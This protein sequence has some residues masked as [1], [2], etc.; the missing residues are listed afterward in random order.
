MTV[1]S[2]RSH[3]FAAENSSLMGKSMPDA[4]VES[5]LEP[6]ADSAQ[7]LVA[8]SELSQAGGSAV[9]RQG[10]FVLLKGLDESKLTSRLRSE[11]LLGS[12][13]LLRLNERKIWSKM[14]QAAWGGA[15]DFVFQCWGLSRSSEANLQW[16]FLLGFT[17][18]MQGWSLTLAG[19]SQLLSRTMCKCPVIQ[20]WFI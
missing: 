4:P 17:G 1:P 13:G 15:L 19:Y 7:P 3:W 18:P 2:A 10:S 12:M 20:N 6:Q 11:Q 14:C 16:C 8:S 9:N 5:F